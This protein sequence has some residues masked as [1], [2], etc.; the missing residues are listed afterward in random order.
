M[1]SRAGE[2]TE[3]LAAV[4]NGERDAE[5]RL[6]AMIYPQLRRIAHKHMRAERPDHTLQATALV[7]EAYLRLAGQQNE[8][9]DRNH[10][11]AAAAQAMRQI[12]VDYARQHRAAKRGGSYQRIDLE[13]VAVSTDAYSTK[14]LALD[15]ALSRLEEWD[16]RQS[17]IVELRFFGGLCEEEIAEILGVSV[18]T[19]KRDWRLAKVWLYAEIGR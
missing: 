11:Y 2:I 3:L 17:R 18:R 7:N 12:L 6:I 15:E 4:R 9:N 16:P 8:F 13:N 1:K 14:L 19:V 5:S 10:F